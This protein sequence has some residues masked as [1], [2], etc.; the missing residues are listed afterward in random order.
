MK[1]AVDLDGV[2]FNSEMFFMAS[3]EIYDAKIL[4]KNSIIKKDEPRVQ[5]KY[6]W[7]QNELDGYIKN[8]ANSLDFDVMPCAKTVIDEMKKDNQVFIISARGQFN[9][10]E[11]KIAKSKLRKAKISFNKS[12]FGFLN[13]TEIVLSNKIDV[14]IDDRYDVCKLLSKKGVLSLYFRMAGRKK[15]KKTE[16]LVEVN[17]W[18]DVYRVLVNR[19][20]IKGE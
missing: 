2:V 12:F 19:N 9:P 1:I 5:N 15:L 4:K 3:A 17:N 13:K 16:N 18:G 14:I 11:I 20:I 6:S 10:D 7:S 8:Y